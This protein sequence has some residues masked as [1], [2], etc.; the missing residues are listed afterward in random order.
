MLNYI[1]KNGN[2]AMLDTD[3]EPTRMSRIEKVGSVHFERK[4]VE[5]KKPKVVKE[6]AK[7]VVEEIIEDAIEDAIEEKDLTDA[8][9]AFLKEKKVRGYGLLK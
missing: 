3:K 8:Y 7:V 5:V 9:K 6:V 1:D 4:V 2:R